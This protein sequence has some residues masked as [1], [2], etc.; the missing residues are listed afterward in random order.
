VEKGQGGSALIYHRPCYDYLRADHSARDSTTKI[1][2]ALELV[3]IN[4]FR[5]HLTSVVTWFS[6]RPGPVG[7]RRGKTDWARVDVLSDREISAIAGNRRHV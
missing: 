2:Y 7:R 4:P 3:R 1:L 5:G 6:A